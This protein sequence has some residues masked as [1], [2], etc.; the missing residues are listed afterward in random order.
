M[1]DPIAF[2]LIA[3][4]RLVLRTDLQ[5]GMRRIAGDVGENGRARSRR[6]SIQRIACPKKTN[7]E[8]SGRVR[9]EPDA[10]ALADDQS[11]EAARRISSPMRSAKDPA[12][13][14]L[15]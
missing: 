15:L 1:F 6:D 14:G 9:Q 5:R 11:L 7:A 4:A 12:C 13:G 8:L 2:I 3:I 10:F